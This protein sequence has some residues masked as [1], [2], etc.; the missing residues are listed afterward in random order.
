MGTNSSIEEKDRENHCTRACA[1]LL[2]L[3]LKCICEIGVLGQWPLSAA[4]CVM[5]QE[6]PQKGKKIMKGRDGGNGGVKC[7]CVIQH[8]TVDLAPSEC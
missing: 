7:V 8:L 3:S 1:A 6:H 2:L 4:S 5:S